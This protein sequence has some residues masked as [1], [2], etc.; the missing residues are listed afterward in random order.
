M[1]KGH[2]QNFNLP[3]LLRLNDL[4]VRKTARN[5]AALLVKD[6]YKIL[7]KFINYAPQAV[8]TLHRIADLK[9]ESYDFRNITD[10]RSMM[11][12]MGCNKFI[13]VLDDIINANRRGHNGFAAECAQKICGDIYELYTQMMAAQKTGAVEGISGADNLTDENDD[14]FESYPLK[15]AIELCDQGETCRKMRVLAVHD[16]AVILKTIVSVLGDD[17]KVFTLSNPTMVEKFLGQITPEL[18]ILD[19]KMPE[20]NGLDL[21]PIIRN[22]EGH[23]DTPIIFLTSQGTV[24]H[25]A[26]A[27]ALGACDFIVKPFQWSILREK[28]AKHIVR[29]KLF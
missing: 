3:A 22:F 21:I 28:V 19:Y 10:I 24:D 1:G 2:T 26:A 23:K 25:V 20:I 8:E 29:K 27:L 4:S 18:F 12:D 5:R 6:Y 14:A 17:Y 11:G 16:A 9:G 13:P 7:Y 15:K